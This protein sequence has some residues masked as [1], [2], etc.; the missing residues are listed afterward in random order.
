MRSRVEAIKTQDGATV[1]GVLYSIGQE[2][3]VVM[4]MHPRE[5][6]AAHYMVPEILRGGCAA[7]VQ[8]PRSV[9]NDLR[10]EHEIALYDV[11]AGVAYLKSAGYDNIVLLGNSG[12]ASLFAFYM[13]QASLEPDA[14]ISRTPGGRPTKLKDASLPEADGLVLLAPHPGQGILLMHSIDPSV[15]DERDPFSTD[16]SLSPFHPSNGFKKPPES[17]TYEADFI[18]RYREAQ[19]ARVHVI[20]KVARNAI[21]QRMRAR[22][23]FKERGD[24]SNAV[25][26]A[27]SPIMTV[28]RTDADL[29]CF[30]LSIEPTDRRYGTLWGANPAASNFGA[31]GFARTCTPE[32]WLSTWSGLS[33]NAA[34]VRTLPAVKAPTLLI[35]YTGDNS[36][37]PSDINAVTRAL[38]ASDIT[39]HDI[40]GDHHGAALSEDEESGQ[41]IAGRTLRRWL[42][43]RFPDAKTERDDA[44]AKEAQ[45]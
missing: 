18:R 30:D 25:A 27:Y 9:G 5:F 4:A 1:S 35:A 28:W 40:R 21:E 37:F 13:E 45:Q 42:C 10:L 22:R 14:R 3:T 24:F 33:S 32:S 29:R 39:K 6:I 8:A 19:R 43:E 44:A 7:W 41:L 2:R 31:V 34:L 15:T 11:A 17:A 38:G 12:G 16:E 36:V 23:K 20:D 26:A